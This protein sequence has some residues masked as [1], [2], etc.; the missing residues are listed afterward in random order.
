MLKLEI[1]KGGRTSKSPNGTKRRGAIITVTAWLR[2]RFARL[3][4]DNLISEVQRWLTQGCSIFES[5]L[6]ELQKANTPPISEP[7]LLPSN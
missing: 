3:R 5:E 7:V 6:A 2:T 1:R 4:I